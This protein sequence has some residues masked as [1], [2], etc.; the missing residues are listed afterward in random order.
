MANL[1]FPITMKTYGII[2]MLFYVE[3]VINCEVKILKKSFII[4][5]FSITSI[6]T[7]DNFKYYISNGMSWFH[8]YSRSKKTRNTP[9]YFNTNYGIEMKL[10]HFIMDYCLLHFDA[11]KF[12]LLV[13]V[14]IGSLLKLKFFNVNL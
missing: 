1:L 2:V 5:L 3:T 10:V 12:F 7:D 4:N 6:A 11:L 14:L 13:C 8:M 9:T